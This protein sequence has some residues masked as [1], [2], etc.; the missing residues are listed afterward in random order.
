MSEQPNSITQIPNEWV[1]SES[2]GEFWLRGFRKRHHS[3]RLCK[4]EATSLA[5]TI[6]FNKAKINTFFE[7]LQVVLK[8]HN[9]EPNEIYNIDETGSSA[10]H[11]PPKILSTK[12]TKQV[13][14]VTSGESK[15]SIKMTLCVN[16]IG[17]SNHLC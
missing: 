14:S 11:E 12:G 5:R 17:N 2:A 15:F 4:S 7:N 13:G 6:S 1:I 8:R 3:L 9:F 16:T 10:V